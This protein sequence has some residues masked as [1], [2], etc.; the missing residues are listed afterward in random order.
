MQ[1]SE[2]I[3][4]TNF[5]ILLLH[6]SLGLI[7]SAMMRVMMNFDGAD[8]SLL[9]S[10]K[11]CVASSMAHHFEHH[12]ELC[13]Y[14]INVQ[15]CFKLSKK[16]GCR[17]CLDTTWEMNGIVDGAMVF[18]E[19]YFP[20]SLQI[21]MD[22]DDRK[23]IIHECNASE[24]LRY[25]IEDLLG[26]GSFQNLREDDLR[27]FIRGRELE[28]D[29]VNNELL[30]LFGIEFPDEYGLYEVYVR[31]RSRGGGG[32]KRN[33]VDDLEGKHRVVAQRISHNN[34]FKDKAQSVVNVMTEQD[35]NYLEQSLKKMDK[36]KIGEVREAFENCTYNVPD[37]SSK[38]CPLFEPF[39]EQLNETIKQAEEAKKVVLTSFG[40]AYAKQLVSSNGSKLEHSHLIRLLDDRMKEIENDEKM[41]EEISRRIAQLNIGK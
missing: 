30:T 10:P 2:A 9:V 18:G 4:C 13:E 32:T 41:E 22:W 28:K 40:V 21:I 33:R 35:N 38:L 7:H 26:L 23:R 1:I 25:I 17:I 24:P 3:Y 36:D 19:I 20:M 31:I 8:V 39:I 27:F 37:I 15:S 11:E 29:D 34:Q 5:L 12:T 16:N 14:N 6:P